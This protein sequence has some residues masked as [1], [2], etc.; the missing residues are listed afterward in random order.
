MN[1]CKHWLRINWVKLPFT[2]SLGDW[3]APRLLHFHQNSLPRYQFSILRMW[4]VSWVSKEKFRNQF[5][6]SCYFYS[7]WK[8]SGQIFSTISDWCGNVVLVQFDY[9]SSRYFPTHNYDYPDISKLTIMQ[10]ILYNFDLILV[11]YFQTYM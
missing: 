2:F 9:V 3:V 11:R 4:S 10:I 6:L 1:I 7:G 5:D 8:Y